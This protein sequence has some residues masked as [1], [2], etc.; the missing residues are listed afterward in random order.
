MAH[1]YSLDARHRIVGF[2]QCGGSCREAAR[3][4]EVSPRF[5]VKLVA[6]ARLTGQALWL[7][8]SSC[9]PWWLWRRGT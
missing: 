1:V 6:R 9:L 4:F 5:A 8:R 7:P 2:V 3:D